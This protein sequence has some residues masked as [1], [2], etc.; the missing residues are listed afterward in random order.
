MATETKH[1]SGSHNTHAR[2]SPSS[3]KSWLGCP[4]SLSLIEQNEE[5][6]YPQKL[7]EVRN[8][9]DYIEGLPK[10]EVEDYETRAITL[11]KKEPKYK[12]LSKEEVKLI[13]SASGSVPAREGTRAH[14]FATDIL[15]G[16]KKL[17]NI[18][19][20]FQEPVGMYVDYCR[21]VTPEDAVPYVEEKAPL[22]Y[23]E[24]LN[25]TGTCDYAVVTDE[26]VFVCDLKYGK[27]HLV[28]AE[29]NEQLAIYA[30]SFIKS[31]EG[32]YAFTRSTEVSL[33]IIQPRHRESSG[34]STWT[35]SLKELERFCEPIAE[36]ADLIRKNEDLPFGPSDDTCLWCDAKA[37]CAAREIFTTGELLPALDPEQAM[38]LLPD[39]KPK[40]RKEKGSDVVTEEGLT[41]LGHETVDDK[42]LISLWKKS[43]AIK[44]LLDDIAG[45][46]QARGLL[47]DTFDDAVKIVA[48]TPGN[49]K[50]ESP[51]IAEKFLA[52][53]KLN[54]EERFSR[55]VISPT[56]AEKLLANKF[57]S[58]TRT[59]N[60]FDTLIS[61]A[62]GANKVVPMEDKKPAISSP[63]DLLP[64]D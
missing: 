33:N 32:L 41:I 19:E 26:H 60:K 39:Y 56:V 28:Q 49:R 57:K 48:G 59:K 6:I 2:L 1:Q 7:R 61:R 37:F 50:W 53:Q 3:S 23:S 55:T 29:G 35:I 16:T 34:V 43:K 21:S 13:F 11:A 25:D 44:S 12:T 9:T 40:E 58:S 51:E 38:S 30:M 15:L 24:N 4:A 22:F 52:G 20:D 36:G 64:E 54:I 17:E 18:P 27:G 63:I 45:H 5:R 14:E 8:L 42:L 31:L 62:D 10:D 47:G 46:I